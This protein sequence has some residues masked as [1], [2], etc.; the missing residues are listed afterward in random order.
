M[1]GEWGVGAS[2]AME[3]APKGRRGV[4]SGFLQ[5]AYATGY[6]LAAI[7]FFF[8]F[9]RWGWRP[10][11]FIGGLAALLPVFLRYGVEESEGLGR[12]QQQELSS[13]R[14]G[15]SSPSRVLL[16]LTLLLARIAFVLH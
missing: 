13:L 4:L 7:C 10:M 6:L 8:V 9:P 16:Y 15:V 5:E 1:G 2:L 3:K 11:F 12:T 14:R